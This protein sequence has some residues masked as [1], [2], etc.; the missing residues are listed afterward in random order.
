MNANTIRKEATLESAVR[1]GLIHFKV[2]RGQAES[3][4]P[5]FDEFEFPRE[6]LHDPPSHF[7]VNDY[8]YHPKDN[9]YR[10]N[11][12]REAAQAEDV[13]DIPQLRPNHSPRSRF[14]RAAKAFA[15]AGLIAFFGGLYAGFNSPIH[16]TRPLESRPLENI[17][18]ASLPQENQAI[19]HQV[20][21]LS[22]LMSLQE[23]AKEEADQSLQAEQAK[24][25]VDETIQ[26]RDK[27]LGI[28]N[29]M[30][31]EYHEQQ[32]ATASLEHVQPRAEISISKSSHA[33]LKGTQYCIELFKGDVKDAIRYAHHVS[34]RNSLSG[35]RVEVR[36]EDDKM[37]VLFYN[38]FKSIDEAKEYSKSLNELF[39]YRSKPV[40]FVHPE[41]IIDTIIKAADEQGVD[42]NLALL[43][44]EKESGFWQYSRSKA[45]AVGVFQLMPQAVLDM[46]RDQGIYTPSEYRSLLRKEGEEDKPWGNRIILSLAS[47]G[48]NLYDVPTNAKYGTLKLKR[49]TEFFDN[50]RN[51]LAS[52][53]AGRDNVLK[54]DGIPPFAE[55]RHFVKKIHGVYV[56]N[57]AGHLAYMLEKYQCDSLHVRKS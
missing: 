50:V 34:K 51:A 17:A 33:S 26:I 20:F 40:H 2:Y 8:K 36:E 21:D 53:N 28:A 31:N 43:V 29:K 15:A 57:L 13:V 46:A 10:L 49:E 4:E 35:G 16:E 32:M 37:A 39:R 38:G 56:A 19:E 23:Q 22:F 52:Y 30:M 47:K 42:P 55:T 27:I 48:I 3:G 11:L 18:V 7:N 54:Y 5:I 12:A 1:E 45:G 6:F 14:S 24:F 44:A 25:L 9:I 41:T